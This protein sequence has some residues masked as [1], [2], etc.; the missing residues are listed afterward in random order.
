M[1]NQKDNFPLNISINQH[2]SSKCRTNE[3]SQNVYFQKLSNVKNQ[4]HKLLIEA[5]HLL[6]NFYLDPAS[7]DVA[8]KIDDTVVT[9]ADHSIH[10]LLTARLEQFGFN[11][12]VISEE[13]T[14]EEF[15]AFT[16]KPPAVYW[17]ID[18]LDGTYGFVRGTGHFAVNVALIYKTQAIAGWIAWPRVGWVCWAFGDKSY[19]SG[20]FS[21]P[22][23][24][25][26]SIES[27]IQLVQQPNPRVLVSS[28]RMKRKQWI[29]DGLTQHFG[30]PAVSSLGAAIKFCAMFRGY[31]DLYPRLAGT[32]LW[33]IAP[34]QVL[35]RARGGEIYRL[36]GSVMN[37]DFGLSIKNSHFLAVVD[38]RLPGLPN[39]LAYLETT[40]QS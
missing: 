27:L 14:A 39:F 2:L 12:P 9:T 35:L 13:C 10:A 23:R 31:G 36:D 32:C 17:L 16:A 3:P 30:V 4:L 1:S 22:V 6:N 15:A 5:A 20:A 38:R 11:I 19:D 24:E 18:P 28:S 8:H 37:Y 25:P 7:W 40:E 29:V 33:D 26:E 21:F 34:G